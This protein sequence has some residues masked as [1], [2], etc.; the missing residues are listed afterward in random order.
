MP[1]SPEDSAKAAVLVEEGRSYRYVAEVLGTTPST[2]LRVLRRFREHNTYRRLPGSGHRRC[3]LAR[4]DR[5]LTMVILRDRHL[6]AVEAINHLEQ[7]RNANISDWTARRRLRE[8]NLTSR[9]PATGLQLE[10]HHK[11]ARLNFAREHVEWTEE[12][13]S[14]VLYTDESRFNRSSPDGRESVWRR[15]GERYSACAMSLRTAYGGGSVMVWCGISFDGRTDLVFVENGSLTAP[16]Y[17]EEIL[18]PLD[19]PYVPHIG[20]NFVLMHE[21]ARAHVARCVLRFLEETEI[22]TLEWPARSPD[23]NLIEHMWDMLGRRVCRRVFNTLDEVR[24]ALVEEWNAIQQE[25]IRTIILSMPARMQ[26]VIEARGGNTS[27]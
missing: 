21:N 16:R 12:Q 24:A 3:T 11:R 23:L 4:D 19:I 13:W 5:Y 15:P 25:Y 2:V 1:L 26:A 14:Q 8:V 6:T 9:K 7:V 10:L 20:E 27:Y 22:V 18:L 17:I